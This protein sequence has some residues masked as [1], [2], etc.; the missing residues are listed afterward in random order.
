MDYQ[1][2]EE[3]LK[4]NPDYDKKSRGNTHAVMK[5]DQY[6]YRLKRKFLGEE[7][8]KDIITQLPEKVDVNSRGV[9]PGMSKLE[10]TVEYRVENL[11]SANKALEIILYI[12]G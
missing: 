2:I 9:S 6:Q 4:M 10:I 8:P 12:G 5:L 7:R 1:K 11:A 3:H